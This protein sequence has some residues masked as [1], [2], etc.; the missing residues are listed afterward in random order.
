MRQVLA[1]IPTVLQL[2]VKGDMLHTVQ[3]LD[4]HSTIDKGRLTSYKEPWRQERCTQA[5]ATAG[6]YEA[7]ASL[8]WVDPGLAN[9]DIPLEVATFSTVHRYSEQFFSMDAVLSHRGR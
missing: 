4:I 9:S 7:G 5:L 8:L 3:P 1:R 2:S 6:M